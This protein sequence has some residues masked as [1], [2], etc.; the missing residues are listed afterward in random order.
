MIQKAQKEGI[1][2]HKTFAPVVK[3]VSLRILLA[4]AAS[5]WMRTRHCDIVSAFLHG[6]IDTNVYMQQVYGFNDGTNRV[7]HLRKALYGL[8]QAARQFYINLDSAITTLGYRRLGDLG[9][10]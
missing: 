3:F 4:R 6:D 10:Q 8:C 1:D 7:C 2:Y 9:S 5:L